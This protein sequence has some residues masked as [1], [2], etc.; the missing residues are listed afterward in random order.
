LPLKA[1]TVD[2]FGDSLAQAIEAAM[3]AAWPSVMGAGQSFQ[4][5]PQLKLLCVAVAQGVVRH[6][7]DNAGAF[8][9]TVTDAGGLGDETGQVSSIETTGTIY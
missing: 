5:N 2:D 8:K 4:S 1:G 7:R 6:L 3:Q 9:V